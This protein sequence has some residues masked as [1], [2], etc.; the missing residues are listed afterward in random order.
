MEVESKEYVPSSNAV[1]VTPDKDGGVLKEILVEGSSDKIP[2]NGNKIIVHYVGTLTDG[3][4]FDSSRD[5]GTPFDFML[6]KGS[7]IR[8]WDIGVATMRKGEKAV[9]TC[10]PEYA[11]GKQG[12]PPKIPPDATLIFEGHFLE[13]KIELLD[14]QGE[15]LSHKKDGGII[16]E[17]ITKGE[18]YS[19]PND[20]ALVEG[21]L[22]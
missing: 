6:G 7:V 12:S 13:I 17:Q 16:R 10:K 4:K 5:R 3:T 22:V 19:N 18:G 9:F 14:F 15:D 21:N 20:G 8:A 1:D 2:A 11:Y